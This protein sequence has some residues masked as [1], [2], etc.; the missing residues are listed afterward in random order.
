MTDKRKA[1]LCGIAI[2]GAVVLAL[3]A[4]FYGA[5]QQ[6]KANGISISQSLKANGF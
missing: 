4:M 5:Y 3:G 6:D 1:D 2:I